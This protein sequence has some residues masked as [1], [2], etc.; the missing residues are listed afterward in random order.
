MKACSNFLKAFQSILM[1]RLKKGEENSRIPKT[2]GQPEDEEHQTWTLSPARKHDRPKTPVKAAPVITQLVIKGAETRKH[3]KAQL[4]TTE[5]KMSD[6]LIPFEGRG[7]SGCD[8]VNF[9]WRSENI[10]IMD[11]HRAAMWCWFQHI[12]KEE[13]YNIVRIDAHYNCRGTEADLEFWLANLPDTPAISLNDYLEALLP[14]STPTDKYPVVFWDNFLSI[15]MSKY[16]HLINEYFFCT[17]GA[18]SKPKN[19]LRVSDFDI[20]QLHRCLDA[21]LIGKKNIIL[22]IDIDSCCGNSVD[23][24]FSLGLHKES[25]NARNTRE[26]DLKKE[27]VKYGKRAELAWIVAARIW[28]N[29]VCTRWNIHS[30]YRPK[31]LDDRVSFDTLLWVSSS[32]LRQNDSYK[33]TTGR[34]QINNR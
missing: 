8:K 34:R 33:K 9:V 3:H 2:V 15:F 28:G 25:T 16:D 6:W 32:Y 13:K 1:N 11:N 27:Y 19:D 14:T 31:E 24:I 23:F 10:Y 7:H 30:R 18:G 22:D 29:W 17:H 12:K 21:F 4:T 20:F 5:K 26:I